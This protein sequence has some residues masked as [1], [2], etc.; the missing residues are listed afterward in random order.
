MRLSTITII[1]TLS[2]LV[3]TTS[4][5]STQL[6]N[7]D[8]TC[9]TVRY[10]PPSV[11]HPPKDGYQGHSFGEWTPP[12]SNSL[13]GI[14]HVTHASIEQPNSSFVNL[15]VERYPIFPIDKDF[16]AGSEAE[17]CSWSTCVDPEATNC[18][19]SN[20]I[21]TMFGHNIPI[22]AQG[23][24]D[25]KY[26]AAWSY[27]AAGVL[28]GMVEDLHAVIAWGEDQSG[29]GY[30]AQYETGTDSDASSGDG[31]I[32]ASRNED[33]MDLATYICLSSSLKQLAEELGDNELSAIV[34][35]IKPLQHDGR[36]HDEGP[37]EC[38]AS[39]V[40]NTNSEASEVQQLQRRS[41][42]MTQIA[43]NTPDTRGLKYPLGGHTGGR[44]PWWGWM[45]MGLVF[46]IPLFGG[47]CI[48]VPIAL[49]RGHRRRQY[50]R[51]QRAAL[52]FTHDRQLSSV[53]EPEMVH[54]A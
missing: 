28:G 15:R 19:D 26:T 45:T 38:D 23:P 3:M 30:F 46:G 12:P 27:S 44:L 11:R 4:A 31:I 5:E 10:P 50:A 52:G 20:A 34:S 47:L 18:E 29:S 43:L 7:T 51:A 9:S 39:C 13:Y 32:I 24:T 35:Q 54:T 37:V 22:G 1:P 8:S 41:S 40:N 17:V 14:Y 33:G 36:R 53:A 25:K 48:A 42:S 6:R 2:Y 49:C 16:P 21:S